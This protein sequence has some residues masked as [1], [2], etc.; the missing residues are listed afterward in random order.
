M[1]DNKMAT[2]ATTV[3]LRRPIALSHQGLGETGARATLERQMLC[4]PFRSPIPA[5]SWPR[6]E[7]S[8]SLYAMKPGQQ[9]PPPLHNAVLPHSIPA[10]S[11]RLASLVRRPLGF[12]HNMVPA[13][14]R[15]VPQA[16]GQPPRFR[17]LI[18]GQFDSN[19][20]R[21][22]C[23]LN[24]VY[25]LQPRMRWVTVSGICQRM[26]DFVYDPVRD[27]TGLGGQ[28]TRHPTS[29]QAQL[30]IR[31]T[32]GLRFH[33]VRGAT[34]CA[35]PPRITAAPIPSAPALIPGQSCTMSIRQR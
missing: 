18:R 31:N 10:H 15:A 20:C 13:L 3:T 4:W 17:Y 12:L 21:A 24:P 32:I 9:S 19:P 1:P 27:M 8:S 28:N 14:N 30:I 5:A 35:A 22:S 25:D 11:S 6:C 34:R 16:A 29:H 33:V 26:K 23:M 2:G 7:M